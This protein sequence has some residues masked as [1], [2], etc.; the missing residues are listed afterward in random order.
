VVA[1]ET[2]TELSD[3]NPLSWNAEGVSNSIL[4]PVTIGA[5]IL[6]RRAASVPMDA[7]KRFLR[8]RF[9]QDP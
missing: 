1:P 9:L 2:S 4:G 8:L 3:A 7:P 5:E 6:E